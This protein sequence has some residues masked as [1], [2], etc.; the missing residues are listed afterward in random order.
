MTPE[1][2]EQCSVEDIKGRVDFDMRD[3]YI[4][5]DEVPVLD[6]DSFDS[7]E[8]L[9]QALRVEPDIYSNVQDAVTQTSLTGRRHANGIR[10]LVFTDS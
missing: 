7:A 2:V 1:G 9:I 10:L 4:Y 6:L 5:Y 8:E 3:Y